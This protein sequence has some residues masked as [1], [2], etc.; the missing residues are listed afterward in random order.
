[1]RNSTLNK[2]S[3]NDFFARAGFREVFSGAPL[4]FKVVFTVVG[5]AVVC[6][7]AFAGFTGV[8]HLTQVNTY[9][10]C[11]VNGVHFAID[12]DGHETYRVLSSCGS[13]T[14]NGDI[15]YGSLSG[16]SVTSNLIEGESYTFTATGMN[17]QSM[18]IFPNIV[19]VQG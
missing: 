16:A 2:S 8:Q 6:G 7:V 12:E 14:A 13:F 17:N 10:D 5:I 4:L 19:E 9:E 3:R 1:M 11:K 15:R 18:G